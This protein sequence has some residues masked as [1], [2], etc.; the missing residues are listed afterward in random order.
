[1]AVHVESFLLD[2]AATGTLQEQIQRLVVSGILDGRYRS[3]DRLPSSRGLAAHLGVSRITVT[4]AYTELVAGDYLVSRGRSGYFV[5]PRAPERPKHDAPRPEASAPV[6]WSARLSE[7]ADTA[8]GPSRP[9]DWRRYR[10]NFI[11]GQ[12]DPKLFD[13]RHWRHCALKALGQRDFADLAG[14]SYEQDDPRLIERI[15]ADIL[16]RRGIRAE[17]DEVLITLGAQHALWLAARLLATQNWCVAIEALC[18]PP[19][20]AILSEA[21]SAPLPVPVDAEGLDPARLP[22]G[23]DVAF[24]TVSHHC[25]TNATM[26]LARR[27]ALL[28]AAAERDFVIVEDDYEFEIAAGRAPLP[29]L[30][31]L[32]ADGRVIHVGSFSK[33]LFPGLRLGFMVGAPPLIAAARRL[34][35]LQLRHPPGHIQRTAAYFMELGHYDAQLARMARA[36]AERRKVLTEAIASNGLTPALPDAQGGSSIWMQAP[37]AIDAADLAASL[38][39]RGVVIEAGAVFF[40]P[41]TEKANVYRLGLSSIDA[42]DIPEG[43]ALI[44]REIARRAG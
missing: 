10:Y 29:A 5:S 41:G 32:D 23:T 36:Y 19:L 34:R 43:I 17:P 40:A 37:E 21:G 13:H 27:R 7:R 9:A 14:D 42:R 39:E 35:S 4:L 44:A 15:C 6:D 30:K 38:R 26:P 11:Y 28:A 3:G 8:T 24:T 1:M 16:P 22:E 18:Y 31:A 2:P 20:R 33:S 12:T 25:P